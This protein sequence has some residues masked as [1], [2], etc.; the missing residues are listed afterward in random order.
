MLNIAYCH[1]ELWLSGTQRKVHGEKLKIFC[2]EH[3]NFINNFN[4]TSPANHR[5][6]FFSL[7]EFIDLL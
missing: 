6:D 5:R 4:E 1:D 7:F 3:C 2:P